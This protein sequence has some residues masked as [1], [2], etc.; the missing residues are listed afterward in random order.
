M[1][2]L[3]PCVTEFYLGGQVLLS[4]AT[5]EPDRLMVI[6]PEQMTAGVEAGRRLRLALPSDNIIVLPAAT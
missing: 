1:R 5:E 4:F 6:A 3:L 2:L